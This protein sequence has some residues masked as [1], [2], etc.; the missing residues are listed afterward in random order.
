MKDPIDFT[1][2][3]KNTIFDTI[4]DEWIYNRE[5]NTV[6][7]VIESMESLVENRLA[8]KIF[9]N[10]YVTPMRVVPFN[11]IC[12]W[13]IDKDKSLEK[14]VRKVNAFFRVY[15]DDNKIAIEY[16]KY[17]L[18]IGQYAVDL[19]K[20]NYAVLIVETSGENYEQN[21]IAYRLYFVGK[22][23][24]KYRNKMLDL[25]DKVP[26]M[27]EN[28]RYNYISY[29]DGR[30][31]KDATFKTFDKMVLK[32]KSEIIGYIDNWYKNI[33]AYYERGVPAK[34]SILLYGKPGT[35]KSSF[36]QALAKHL[37]MQSIVSLSSDYF[38]TTNDPNSNNRGYNNTSSIF[39]IDEIDCICNSRE[40]DNSN[41]NKKALSKLLDFLDNPPTTYIK[42][43]DG[44]Y[45]SV[46]IVVATT[47][48]FDRLD[49]AVKRYGRFDRKIE[50]KE[51]NKTEAFELCDIFGVDYDLIPGDINSSKFS[52]SPAYLQ[53]L[54]I[55][56]IDSKIKNEK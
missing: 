22:K 38:N 11:V 32:N 33:P 53:A 50:L 1:T 16:S 56:N 12:K 6:K 40:T 55:E 48:Y 42:A 45:Y 7:R 23:C 25:F 18:D 21:D 34:L 39:L 41:E 36:A 26:D 13:L 43:E 28:K 20:R 3:G 17:R 4:Y 24:V 27:N 35:G 51:F 47:N 14:Y 29:L 49:D 8:T 5:L 15:A 9:G 54:C 2:Y 46:S 30:P 37:D 31:T 19:G 44:K 10:E 52:I